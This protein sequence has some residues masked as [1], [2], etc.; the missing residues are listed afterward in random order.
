MSVVMQA[1]QRAEGSDRATIMGQILRL[2]ATASERFLA[3]FEEPALR[4]YLQKLQASQQPRGRGA[5]WVRSE[6][7]PG[8]TGLQ[9]AW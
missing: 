9:S 1:G 6:M 4:S 2:N 8:I 7:S 3:R 5:V